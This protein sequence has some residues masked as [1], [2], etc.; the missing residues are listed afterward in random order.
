MQISGAE[1]SGD[2]LAAVRAAEAVLPSLQGRQHTSTHAGCASPIAI[3]VS[4]LLA[5]LVG[6]RLQA[7]AA[8]VGYF[9]NMIDASLAKA[10]GIFIVFWMAALRRLDGVLGPLVVFARD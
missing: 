4:A 7:L 10:F 9:A 5:I 8:L 1:V 3:L 6:L 2:R